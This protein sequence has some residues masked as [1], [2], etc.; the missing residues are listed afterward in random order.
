M[1]TAILDA[2]L[3]G[4]AVAIEEMAQMPG[5]AGLYRRALAASVT[6]RRQHAGPLPATELVVRGVA[7]ER[8]HLWRYARVCGFR[9]TDAL[10]PTYPHV[11]AFPLALE[12]MTRDEFPFT[13]IGLVHI[14]NTI[15]QL[16]AVDA[17]E[18]LDFAVRAESLRE[19]DR[20]HA[21]DVV[22]TLTVNGSVFW[23]GRATYLRRDGAKGG[24]R[25]QGDRRDRSD[26]RDPNGGPPAADALWRVGVDVGRAYAAASGD[27][28][29]IHT[30]TLAARAF[31]FPRR[32]AHGM[33]STARCLGALEGRVPDQ[34]TVDV[35]FKL[36]ILLPA[37]VGFSSA[38]AANG[39]WRFALHDA[40]SG[41]P[42]LDGS[43]A[44]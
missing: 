23:R 4:V 24:R 18:R 9:L 16:G 5:V 34:F 2:S 7:I 3:G 32:I 43:L 35:L 14:G 41:R 19:H 30:S 21:V 17:G 6:R 11:L 15:E 44:V 8:E 22:T 29:P 10:P 42:H 27:R 25:N 40:T 26:R 31:G 38:R 12:L 36:P 39:G 28:N 37:T 13:L 1:I 20:G 33:W